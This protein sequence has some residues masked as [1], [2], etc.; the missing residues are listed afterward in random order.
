[1][2]AEAAERLGS[3]L[4]WLA[5][6]L[7][8][9]AAPDVPGHVLLRLAPRGEWGRVP[10]CVILRVPEEVAR[11]ND[12]LAEMA[13]ILAPMARCLEAG[14]LEGGVVLRD[15]LDELLAD[16]ERRMRRGT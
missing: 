14:D 4:E 16:F 11:C 7:L 2:D 6:D 3:F 12:L 10:S 15:E 13:G 1:M 9:E 8:C 5:P